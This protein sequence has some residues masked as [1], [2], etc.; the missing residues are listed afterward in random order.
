MS[1]ECQSWSLSCRVE[2]DSECHNAQFLTHGDGLVSESVCQPVQL[3][4]GQRAGGEL[5]LVTDAQDL[6]GWG[7]RRRVSGRTPRNRPSDIDQRQPRKQPHTVMLSAL[8]SYTYVTIYT[9]RKNFDASH[10]YLLVHSF[11][12]GYR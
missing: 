9:E 10:F 1:G 6:G 11:D 8:S 12:T 5:A 2:C 4:L 7:A 3:L